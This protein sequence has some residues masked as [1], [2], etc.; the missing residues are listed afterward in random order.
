[1]KIA[2]LAEKHNRDNVR[3]RSALARHSN[4][5]NYDVQEEQYE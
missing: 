4:L 1:M 5:I 3:G 2:C